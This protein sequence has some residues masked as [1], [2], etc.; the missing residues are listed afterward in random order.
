[1]ITLFLFIIILICSYQL[2]DVNKFYHKP[3]EDYYNRKHFSRPSFYIMAD[4]GKISGV[5]ISDGRNM[6]QRHSDYFQDIKA[7]RGKVHW[8]YINRITLILISI[9]Y[10]TY[11]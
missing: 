9:A 5:S 1:M 2:C 7:S 3:E 10:I 11:A 8:F 4:K 6:D